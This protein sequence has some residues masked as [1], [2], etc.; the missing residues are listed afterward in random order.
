MA[1]CNMTNR[2]SVPRFNVIAVPTGLGDAA[3][4]LQWLARDPGPYSAVQAMSNELHWDIK[5][6]SAP[7]RWYWWFT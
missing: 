3:V 6:A 7:L 2:V 4:N 5:E 1:C